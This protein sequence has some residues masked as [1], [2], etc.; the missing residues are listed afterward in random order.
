MVGISRDVTELKLVESLLEHQAA[1]ADDLARLRGGFVA[2]VSHE[3]RTPLTAIVGYAELLESHW[4]QIPDAARLERIHRIAGAANR[5]KH[6]V[7]EL[8]I[9]SQMEM[10]A[11]VP[12]IESTAINRLID[13]AA[14]EVRTSYRDQVIDLSGPSDLKVLA[15]P[16]KTVQILINLFDNAAKYSPDSSPVHVSWARDPAQVSVRV[17][18][19]GPGIAEQGRDRLFTRFGC[20]P[21]ARPRAGRVGTGLGLFLSRSFAVA[22]GG[23][24]VLESTGPTGTV[25]RLS[26]PLAEK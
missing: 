3:L 1:A 11:L 4:D 9:L 26:L 17:R 10:G 13:R 12:A 5:Q 7:E 18:D 24:L 22:M 16:E 14:D 25:F 2:S 19:H 8:L 6:L 23:D 15:D 20:V 21:G